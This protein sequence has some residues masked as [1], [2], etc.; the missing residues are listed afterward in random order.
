MRSPLL[1]PLLATSSSSTF[2]SSTS[3]TD[4]HSALNAYLSTQSFFFHDD[5]DNTK[6]ASW[7]SAQC[8]KFQLLAGP[9]TRDPSALPSLDQPPTLRA[10]ERYYSTKRGDRKARK[11]GYPAEKKLKTKKSTLGLRTAGLR[12]IFGM[13][14]KKS[15]FDLFEEGRQGEVKRRTQVDEAP[16]RSDARKQCPKCK[17]ALEKQERTLLVTCWCRADMCYACLRDWDFCEGSCC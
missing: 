14:N 4:N 12:D 1:T 11:D 7:I 17:W 2:S 10:A 6:E 9:R 3:S 15:N 16:P 8:R 5:D 13:G